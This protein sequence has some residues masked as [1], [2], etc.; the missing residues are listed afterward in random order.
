MYKVL[1]LISFLVCNLYAEKK[2][3]VFATTMDTNGSY[4]KASD[5]VIVVYDGLYVSAETASY[6]HNTGILELYGRVHA[7]KG[8][9]YYAMGDY[10]M[11]DTQKDIRQ[12]RPFFLQEYKDQLWMSA[13]SAK[14]VKEEYELHT[15]VVSSC[16]PQDP[17]WTLRFSSGYYDNE[18][19]WMQLYNARL[20]AGEIPVFYLPY[21]AYPTD[22][23]RRTGLLRP[24]FGLS[25]DEGFVYKQP[26]FI[27]E[28]PQWDLELIPEIRTKRGEGLYNTLR[29]VDSP[30]SFGALTIG[31]FQEKSSYQEEFDLLNDKHYGVEFDYEHRGFLK[32]WFDWNVQG[33]SGIYSDITYLNDVEYLN[34]QESDSLN[35]SIDS[36][37]TSKV[38]VFLNQSEDYFG[39][40]S[41]Y[42]IDLTK[43]SNADTIQNLPVLQY[44]RYLNTF[45]DDHLLY[46]FDYRGSNFYREDGKNATQHELTVP[47]D[48]QF[49]LLDEYLTLTLSENLYASGVSFYGSDDQIATYGYSSGVYARDF[50]TV[51]LNTNLVKSFDEFSHSVSLTAA[52]VHPGTDKRTGFYEDYQEEFEDNIANNVPC[53]E[54]PCEYDTITEVLEEASV[55]FTQF[56]FTVNGDEK[57]YH[58]LRQPLIYES[59]Y[60]KY[61]ELENELRYSFTKEFSYYNNTFYNHQRNVI[62]KT[63][64]TLGYND[65]VFIF[66][67]SHLY[68]DRLVDTQRERTRYLTTNARYNYSNRWQYFA[69]YAYDIENSET[70]N[71]SIGFLYKKRCWDLQLKYVE[72]VRPIIDSSGNSSSIQD[73][74]LYLTLNLNPLGGMEVDYKKSE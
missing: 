51:E 27:A 8:A 10:L 63:Q 37:V 48:L 4:V 64:N 18:D 2:V 40:Y 72:N 46:S 42:F 13:R 43:D 54:G 9:E 19:Q 23:T 25:G 45:M 55:E 17:D 73:K 41:K 26:I 32:N 61:G 36:Q 53:A 24:T 6:D 16:N 62:S 33:T 29:F 7:L 38:N 15:G 57:L 14:S 56:L 30:G 39:A 50:Q 5:D 12:F 67:L 74:V 20:Y 65:T 47:L 11:L 31:G 21:M 59:G 44:H 1:I 52:Y 22:T 68:Q 69:G 34:I 28:D 70:K 3:E 49:P 71:R 58:R 60:D 66:N 35:Y